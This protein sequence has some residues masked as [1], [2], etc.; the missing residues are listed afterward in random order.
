M[1]TDDGFQKQEDG[2]IKQL[3]PGDAG[4]A[5]TGHYTYIGQDG[6]RYNIAYVADENGFRPK[7]SK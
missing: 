2:E 5:V 4:T 7:Y 6:T 1:E 3:G